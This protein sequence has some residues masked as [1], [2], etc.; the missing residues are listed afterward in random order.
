MYTIVRVLAKFD[1]VLAKGEAAALILLLSLMIIVVFLQ[2]FFRYALGRPLSW[3]EEMARYLFVWLSVL[4]AALG[5][6]KGGHFGLDLLNRA[7]SETGKRSLRIV[8]AILTAVV[9]L[10]IL[11]QGILLVEKTR[12]QESPAMLIPM[13]WAY[14][15]LPVGAVFMAV[16]LLA[17]MLKETWFEGKKGKG[18]KI[19]EP[20]L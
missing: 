15:A 20:G 5:I 10:V 12:F 2:V 16:H 17:A 6:H 4:G 9:V 3:S 19:P 13:A 14:A 7:L 18:E 11:S 1:R 8:T